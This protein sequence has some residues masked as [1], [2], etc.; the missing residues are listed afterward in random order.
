MSLSRN[1]KS[2]ALFRRFLSP[3]IW[4]WLIYS[5]QCRL[6]EVYKFVDITTV[7]KNYHKKKRWYWRQARCTRAEDKRETR[8]EDDGSKCSAHARGFYE[9]ASAFLKAGFHW[10]WGLSRSR[11]WCRNSPYDLVK[12]KNRS[13][14]RIHDKRDGIGVGRIRTSL[15]FLATLLTTPSR[16]FVLLSSETGEH[17]IVGV[18]SRSGRIMIAMHVR[19][20]C[21]WFSSSASICDTLDPVFT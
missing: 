14:K 7:T 18:G 20:I 19:T 8:E 12:I 5:H 21:D 3:S 13:R 11:K 16:M 6:I 2:S 17:Q 15:D 9:K 4:S 10:R 1:K